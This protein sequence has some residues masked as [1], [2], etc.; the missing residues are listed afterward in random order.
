ML[1]PGVSTLTN[2]DA[3]RSTGSL[4]ADLATSG[5]ILTPAL[6]AQGA[7]PAYVVAEVAV[8]DAATF[9]KDYAPKVA[10][11]LQSYGGRILVGG[12]KLMAVEGDVP[13]RFVVI[14]FDNVDKARGWYDSAAYQQLVSVRQK[15]AKTTL[16][17]AEGVPR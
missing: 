2:A 1:L 8:H 4:F 7:A 16:F 11:T 3:I 5:A 14:A 17:I 12:G 15:T 13:Q 6:M 9:A 10:G